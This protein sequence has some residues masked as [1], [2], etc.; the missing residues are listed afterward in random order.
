M[1]IVLLLIIHFIFRPNVSPETSAEHVVKIPDH[2]IWSAELYKYVSHD[3]LIDYKSW[4][5]NQGPL[6]LYLAALSVDLPLSRWSQNVQLAYW[7][8]IHNAYSVKQVLKHYPV[9]SLREISEGDPKQNQWI[10]LDTAAFSLEEIQQYIQFQFRDPRIYFALHD[11]S[12]SGAPLLNEAYEP[13]RIHDQLN[14]QVRHFIHD[15]THNVINDSIAILSPVFEKHND[16]FTPDLV[17]FLNRYLENPL[18]K[19]IKIVYGDF[20]WSIDEQTQ[21]MGSE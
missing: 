16:A 11:A 8:N 12:V 21:P 15:S 6:D 7:L 19:G 1:N 5:E 17:T 13:N 4:K 20:D 10:V 3:G 2:S 9:T 14:E 18:P